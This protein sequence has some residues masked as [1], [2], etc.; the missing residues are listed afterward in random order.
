M[1]NDPKALRAISAESWEGK[2]WSL[3]RPPSAGSGWQTYFDAERIELHL[4]H[5]RHRRAIALR[6]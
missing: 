2:R 6:R 4:A 5:P 1:T 3:S